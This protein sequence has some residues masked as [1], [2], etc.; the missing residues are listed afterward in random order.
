MNAAETVT[1]EHRDGAVHVNGALTLATAR[2][3]LDSAAGIFDGSNGNALIFDLSGVLQSDSAALAV[4]LEWTRRAKRRG[5]ELVYRN[6]SERLRQLAR[7]SDL[8]TV[9]GI[10]AAGQ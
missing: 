1:I 2:G 10:S 9:L 4:L 6:A 5:I 3:A 8:E 7:I